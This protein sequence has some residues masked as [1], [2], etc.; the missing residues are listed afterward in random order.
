MPTRATAVVRFRIVGL[1]AMLSHAETFRVLQRACARAGI[2]VRYSEGFNPH[3]KLSLPL[4]RPVGVE[5]EEELLV[6][7]LYEDPTVRRGAAPAECETA[8]MRALDDQLP[9]GM[10]VLSLTLV[11]SNVSLTPQSAQYV[12]PLRGGAD[13][14]LADRLGCQ[15]ERVMARE[16]CVMERTVD[17]DKPARKIDVRPFLLSIRFEDGRLI[18]RHRTGDA[19]S[20]RLDEI[21]RLFSLR[22]EDLA[23]P[24]QR[25]NV[26]WETTN[27]QQTTRKPRGE[28]GAE[29]I[30]DGS[31]NAD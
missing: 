27:L 8:M 15:I 23:G 7:R 26:V 3:P 21:L 1:V 16:S 18:V 9:E 25:C 22:A 4:P 28:S 29:E 14:G 13:P 24:V 17:R 19:G 5:S 2:P 12:L 20:I 6:A 30:E 31:R 10:D 11:A